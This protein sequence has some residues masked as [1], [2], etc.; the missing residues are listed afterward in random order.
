MMNRKNSKRWLL[1]KLKSSGSKKKFDYTKD[2]NREKFVLD[3]FDGLPKHE[4]M[5]RSDGNI[6]AK[7]NLGPLI[8]FLASNVNKDWDFVYSEY[9][10]RIPSEL[11]FYKDIIFDIVADKIE[12]REDRIIDLKMGRPLFTKET[13]L[14]SP[15]FSHKKFYVNPINNLL[16]KI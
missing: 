9:C 13:G 1:S 14:N 3:Q 6:K 15:V 10:S 11:F 7:L 5:H 12:F 2:Y 16:M 8:S 4:S